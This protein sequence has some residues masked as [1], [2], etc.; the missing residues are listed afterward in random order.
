MKKLL[1]ILSLI[2]FTSALEALPVDVQR[3]Q[4]YNALE[5]AIDSDSY[6]LA[7]KYIPKL[8]AL[9]KDE[10]IKLKSSYYYFK[11]KTSF[12]NKMYTDVYIATE[13]YIERTKTKGKY[14]K[15]ILELVNKSDI[16]LED[17][18]EI[19]RQRE[20][21]I[22]ILKSSMFQDD[23]PN[24]DLSLNWDEAVKYCSELEHAKF[25]DWRL[26]TKN[27]LL[28]LEEHKNLLQYTKAAEY[29]SS[30]VNDEESAIAWLVDFKAGSQSNFDKFDN[31]FNVRCVR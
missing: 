21:K 29:W 3:D 14:Y 24:T 23:E 4:Y 8:D 10:K 25:N 31:Y 27:E 13:K 11:A 1:S 7:Q 22:F 20:L 28:K 16:A 6:E 30:T 15:S 5:K 17:E 18:D 19:D 12:E 9:E 26:S 2:I